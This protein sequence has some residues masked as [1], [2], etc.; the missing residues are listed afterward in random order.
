VKQEKGAIHLPATRKFR[1]E[2]GMVGVLA[3]TEKHGLGGFSLDSRIRGVFYNLPART[4]KELSV[5]VS[6]EARKRQLIYSRD[7]Q[8][9]VIRVMLR[10]TGAMPDQIAYCHIVSIVLLNA[11]KR[12]PDLYIQDFAV[13][14]VIPLLPEEERWLWD[15]WGPGQRENNPILGRLDA[16]VDF[17]SPMWKDTLHIIEP[18]LN[19]VGGVHIGPNCD[20][21]VVDVILPVVR[22]AIPNLHLDCGLDLREMFLQEIKDHLEAI[23]R[24]GGT[25]CLIDPKYAGDGPLEFPALVEHYRRMHGIE[26]VY[27]DANELHVKNGEVMYEDSP[28]TIAYRGYEVRD[29]LDMEKGEGLDTEPFKILFRENRI[30]SS[31]AGDF[32]HK[33]SLEILTD[34]Q[35]TLKYFTPDERHYFRRHVL[36]TRL[37][38]DGRTTDPEGQPID[39]LEWVRHNQDILVLK[40]NRSYGGDRVII[41]PS[42]GKGEWENRIGEA[43]RGELFVVQRL[44]HITV[45]E[46]PLIDSEGR[47]IMEP[48]Y[49]VV[50]FA[51]TK[52]GLAILGRASQDQVVNV[53][54][55]GG[56]YAVLVGQ[57]A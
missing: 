22:E 36:W 28:I 30:I 8:Q 26:I 19:S 46:F 37:I 38:R 17:T 11:F 6:E 20:Q 7:G 53:A 50:G 12:L 14:E 25:I 31:I 10:P 21:L 51:P 13:R 57:Y 2:K 44:A 34:P 1:K 29:L 35:F 48:F 43:L 24:S 49:T 39:L 5:C 9:D 27:A 4:L 45:S 16:T 52:Y 54:Q 32:D 42:V 55:G 56:A 47:V 40:P 41:G 18:N 33:S 23:G 3:P 15:I